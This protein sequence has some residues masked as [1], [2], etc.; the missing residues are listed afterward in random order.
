MS[1][2]MP[3]I[4]HQMNIYVVYVNRFCT[5]FAHPIKDCI[6]VYNKFIIERIRQATT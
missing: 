4:M 2:N 6:Q 3:S 1:I 5:E